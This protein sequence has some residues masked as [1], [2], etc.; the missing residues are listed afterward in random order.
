M[1]LLPHWKRVLLRAWS[2]RF[3][4]LAAILSGLEVAVPFLQ[5]VI[6]IPPGLFAAIAGLVSM[7]A[8]MARVLIQNGGKLDE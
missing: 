6:D 8:L 5:G 4:V 7:L 1:Q 3:I 2:V